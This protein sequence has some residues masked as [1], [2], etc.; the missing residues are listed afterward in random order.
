[1]M[2][3]GL[4]GADFWKLNWSPGKCFCLLW[5]IGNISAALEGYN[6]G[7]NLLL[8]SFSFRH[9]YIFFKVGSLQVLLLSWENQWWNRQGISHADKHQVRLTVIKPSPLFV[10]YSRGDVASLQE[11]A[12]HQPKK[13][14]SSTSWNTSA[15]K[16]RRRSPAVIPQSPAIS[17]CMQMLHTRSFSECF[18]AIRARL[19]VQNWGAEQQQ[20]DFC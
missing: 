5:K 16:S 18:L 12:L 20:G 11:E 7:N 13:E 4:K 9:Y 8:I 2:D 1:M 17:W 19:Q 15:Y 6:L 10:T 14:K 3:Y